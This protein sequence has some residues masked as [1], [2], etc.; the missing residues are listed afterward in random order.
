MGKVTTKTTVYKKGDLIFAKIKGSPYWPARVNTPSITNKIKLFI[1]YHFSQVESTPKDLIAKK[2]YNIIFYGTYDTSICK[3]ENLEPYNDDTKTAYSQP[4]KL[5][6]W[7]EALWEIEHDPQLKKNRQAKTSTQEAVKEE[8]KQQQ[9]QMEESGDDSELGVNEEQDVKTPSTCKSGDSSGLANEED[10][11][12]LSS[13]ESKSLGSRKSMRKSNRVQLKD[14]EQADS[15]VKTVVVKNVSP[16]LKQEID[17]S[18]NDSSQRATR[19]F[20]FRYLFLFLSY[21]YKLLR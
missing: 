14:D 8:P 1:N 21:F 16:K 18:S 20:Q 15:T 6:G 11:N 7:C 5:K 19:R 12:E 9:Q 4:R 10:S 17:E 13:E 2:K 3:V